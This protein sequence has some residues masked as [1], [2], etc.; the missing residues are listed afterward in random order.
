M[1]LGSTQPLNRNEYQ[2][3]SWGGV[4]GGR[5]VW[6]TSPPSVSRLSRKCGILDGSKPYGP[7]RYVT[8]FRVNKKFS[9]FSVI[10]IRARLARKCVV[11]VLIQFLVITWPREQDVARVYNIWGYRRVSSPDARKWMWLADSTIETTCEIV[12]TTLG[13]SCGACPF[14][15]VKQL[16]MPAFRGMTWCEV[17]RCGTDYPHRNYTPKEVEGLDVDLFRLSWL[18]ITCEHP[19]TYETIGTP[20]TFNRTREFRRWLIPF[21]RHNKPEEEQDQSNTK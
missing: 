11:T 3:S 10:Q 8:D 12:S 19:Q 18:V 4:K 21:R 17:P 20:Q 2:K 16:S 1:V 9:T 6:L 15:P 7:P 5:R 13:T 14:L